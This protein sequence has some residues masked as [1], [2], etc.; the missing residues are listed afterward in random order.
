MARET[1]SRICAFN[2]DADGLCALQQLHL[3]EPA[4]ERLVTGPK[5]K[6]ALLDELWAGAGDEVTVLDV[7]FDVNREGVQRLLERGAHVRYFDHHHAGDIPA[8]P[9]LEAYIDASPAVCSSVIVNR[10]LGGRQAAWAVVGAFGDNLDETART[11][12]A[13]LGFA[14]PEVQTLRELGIALNYNAYGESESDLHFAPAE[15]HRRLAR[16][17]EPLAFCR[18][19]P[20]FGRLREGY[21]DDLARADSL[22]PYAQASHAAVYVM[23]CADW[24]RRISG[25]AAGRL[26]RRTAV[27]AHA[28]LVP[29]AAGGWQVSV[30]APL[31]R[32][33]GAS[34][35]CR[36]Y[37]TGGGREGAGGI[38]HLPLNA[39]EQFSRDFLE[40][41]GRCATTA[42]SPEKTGT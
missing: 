1:M 9:R 33:R 10:H 22:A 26:A 5:R 30:R 40:Y 32:P 18:D 17:A 35:F 31:D 28:V 15:L 19:D 7:S 6:V 16:H 21:R 14:E 8:H 4:A 2:G 25:V 20:A 23:P 41:W 37:P 38:N 27:R 3:A 42:L 24:A 36:R 34:A 29:R 11:L 13:S 12:A 39:L